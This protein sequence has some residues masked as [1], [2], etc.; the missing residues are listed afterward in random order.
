[1]FSNNQISITNISYIE[2]LQ[3]I[4]TSWGRAQTEKLVVSELVTKFLAFMELQN[5]LLF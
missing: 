1:M 4:V 3:L 2:Q 5:L